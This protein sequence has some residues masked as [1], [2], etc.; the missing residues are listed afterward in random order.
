MSSI[1]KKQFSLTVSFKAFVAENPKEKQNNIICI[2]S[3]RK[4]S[5]TQEF[6]PLLLSSSS[7][8]LSIPVVNNS[9]EDQ[10]QFIFRRLSSHDF[11]GSISFTPDLFSSIGQK[12]FSQW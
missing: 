3:Y 11:L 9:S 4:S 1:L 10:I 5:V 6:D 12:E 7:N 8:Q 2:T